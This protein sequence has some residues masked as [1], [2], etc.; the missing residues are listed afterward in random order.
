LHLSWP[1]GG[2]HG[3]CQGTA[4][5]DDSVIQVNGNDITI[6]TDAAP[7]GSCVYRNAKPSIDLD[8]YPNVEV[9]LQTTANRAAY[10]QK[11]GM[12]FSFWMYPPS[13]AYEHGIA[14]SGEVDFVENINSVRT[15][16]AGCSHDCHETSWSQAAN[17]VSAH[18]TMHYDSGSQT[19]NVYR[20]AHGS[21]TCGTSGERAY[22]DLQKMQVNKPYTYTFSADC[23]Y[24]QPGFN[25]KLVVS[26]L[27]IM[28]NAVWSNTTLA[29]RTNVTSNPRDSAKTVNV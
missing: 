17:E 16:F 2:G 4:K 29:E 24:A 9:D 8:E 25:F 20:C 28:R 14:E 10:G 21:D 7:S 19:V 3:A 27:R 11:G 13:Y 5:Q 12:W 22:V 6:S 26:N 23:W 1:T 15:N 18:V